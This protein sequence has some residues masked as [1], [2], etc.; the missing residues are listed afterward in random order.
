MEAFPRSGEPVALSKQEAKRRPSAIRTDLNEEVI[1]TAVFI[2]RLFMV[3]D[4]IDLHKFIDEFT[5]FLETKIL[6]RGHLL[7]GGDFNTHVDNPNDR[8]G[9]MFSDLLESLGLKQHIVGPTHK[10]GHT[11]DLLI[12][13][14]HDDHIGGINVFDY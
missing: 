6:Q 3:L 13:R 8:N 11:L 7:I 4:Y 12:T 2:K 14:E 1:R 10:S 5:A 9:Q